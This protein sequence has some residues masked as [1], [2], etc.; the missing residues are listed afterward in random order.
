LDASLQ[1]AIDYHSQHEL[2]RKAVARFADL[3][4][5]EPATATA[6][7]PDGRALMMSGFQKISET[8]LAALE[9]EVL[10][11]LFRDGTLALIYRHLVS[12]GQ[13]QGLLR[14]LQLGPSPKSENV[15]RG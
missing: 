14:R 2:T 3:N 9:D 15:A 4:L 6:N 8:K 12:L 5:F 13:V 1:F 10:L 11:A 7:L